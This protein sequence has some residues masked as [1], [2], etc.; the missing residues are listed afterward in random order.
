MGDLS[1]VVRACGMCAPRNGMHACE[2]CVCVCVCARACACASLSPSLPLSLSARVHVYAVQD[3]LGAGGLV[4]LLLILLWPSGH[5]LR[6]VVVLA[7]SV[8][9]TSSRG[10]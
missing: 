5:N 10:W 6:H 3:V 7:R 2:V 8:A 1:H 9:H 4:L